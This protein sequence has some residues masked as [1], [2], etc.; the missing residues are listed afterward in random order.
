MPI[1]WGAYST[2]PAVVASTEVPTLEGTLPP[3]PE[4]DAIVDEDNKLT[5]SWRRWF[6]KQRSWLSDRGA[7]IPTDNTFT[8]C[9]AGAAV[10][11]NA[12][13]HWWKQG[14]IIHLTYETNLTGI[15]TGGGTFV[16]RPLPY[17]PTPKHLGLG[18]TP[19]SIFMGSCMALVATWTT[20]PAYCFNNKY[21]SNGTQLVFLNIPLSC[22]RLTF[23]GSYITDY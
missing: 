5:P 7:Y 11:G 23:H 13:L 20:I 16:V 12:P 10:S 8:G 15:T 19:R 6:A 22:T 1:G 17:D 2:P 4:A 14:N 9:G 21:T 3:F 18:P